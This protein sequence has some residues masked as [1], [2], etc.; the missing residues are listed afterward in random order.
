MLEQDLSYL[1]DDVREQLAILELE[2]S[3]GDITQKG[4][5]KKR[6]LILAKYNKGCTAAAFTLGFVQGRPFIH[7]GT[8][9]DVLANQ[10]PVLVRELIVN[11]NAVSHEM[12]LDS[13]PELHTHF[14]GNERRS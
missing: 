7:P 13:I 11:T 2:L 10:K 6:G 5:E 8:F 12:N 9:P 4:Y 3:E 1:P 14:K